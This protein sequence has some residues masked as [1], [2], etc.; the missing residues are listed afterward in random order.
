MPPLVRPS[1][2]PMRRLARVGPWR[3]PLVRRGLLLPDH[4]RTGAMVLALPW[5]VRGIDELMTARAIARRA[6]APVGVTPLAACLEA[7]VATQGLTP[8][9]VD[10]AP[11]AIDTA[12]LGAELFLVP[13][14]LGLRGPPRSGREP[15]CETPG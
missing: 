8:G 11:A 7:V 9:G 15:S 1:G 12:A 5:V 2:A 13:A 14:A 6:V 3:G 4:P 10:P